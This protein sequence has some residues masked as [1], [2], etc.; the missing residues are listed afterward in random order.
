MMKNQPSM[1]ICKAG[2]TYC[3][4]T[5]LLKP[6]WAFISKPNSQKD[7]KITARL[8]LEKLTKLK[9][10]PVEQVILE[11]QLMIDVPIDT[12][13]MLKSFQTAFS[14]LSSSQQ[15]ELLAQCQSSLR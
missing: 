7:T 1:I 6:L 9:R 13:T 11:I 10:S 3:I 5:H 8:F 2:F 15:N 12:Q 14:S 4:W